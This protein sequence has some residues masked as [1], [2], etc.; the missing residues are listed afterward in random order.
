M[1]PDALPFL[2][3]SS[4]FGTMLPTRMYPKAT[5]HINH[6]PPLERTKRILI[7]LLQ[8]QPSQIAI[9]LVLFVPHMHRPLRKQPR[10]YH[11]THLQ[12]VSALLA[13]LELQQVQ[14][15]GSQHEQTGD[16]FQKIVQQQ[17]GQ[18]A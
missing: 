17:S 5:S 15:K 12:V 14:H 18:D 16:Y 13:S 4:S 11:F 6:Q 7:G 2:H 8:D 9:L 10:H 1:V 3:F